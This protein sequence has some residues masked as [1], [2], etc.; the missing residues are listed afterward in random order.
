MG[1]VIWRKH[2]GDNCN[3]LPPSLSRAGAVGCGRFLLQVR[4]LRRTIALAPSGALLLGETS[5]ACP[6]S[7]LPLSCLLFIPVAAGPC[8]AQTG[9]AW[10]L[11]E[12]SRPEPAAHAHRLCRGRVDLGL[13]GR[14]SV[15]AFPGTESG[16]FKPDA[17]PALN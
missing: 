17:N 13:R 16:E 2:K 1:W 6:S 8:P 10:W 9:R 4:P 15:A 11:T 5:L 14:Q 7:S 12:L 3:L